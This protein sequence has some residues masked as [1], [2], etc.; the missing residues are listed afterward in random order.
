GLGLS[1]V[2]YAWWMT[3]NRNYE[4]ASIADFLKER[5]RHRLYARAGFSVA[6]LEEVE[7]R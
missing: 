7:V 6:R 3:T 4:Y 2:S 5:S 1:T